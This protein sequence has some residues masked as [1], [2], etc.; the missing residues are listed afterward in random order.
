MTLGR[1]MGWGGGVRADAAMALLGRS[2]CRV[3]R[4]A[5]MELG[6]PTGRSATTRQG[7]RLLLY[8]GEGKGKDVLGAGLAQYRGGGE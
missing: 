4:N 5:W 3:C 8:P 1:L 6:I 2:A 7:W